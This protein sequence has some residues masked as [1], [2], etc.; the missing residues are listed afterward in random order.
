MT[1]HPGQYFIINKLNP[2]SLI[3]ASLQMSGSHTS[4][5]TPMEKTELEMLILQMHTGY[6]FG[7][8]HFLLSNL[9]KAF[10]KAG[11]MPQIH[12]EPRY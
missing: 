8:W 11:R 5:E 9:Q 2:H 10:T 7:L 6:K 3:T 1:A 4:L 12:T